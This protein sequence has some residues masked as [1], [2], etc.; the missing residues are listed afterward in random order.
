MRAFIF[1]LLLP[2]VLSACGADA[3]YA[4]DAE[5]ARA[6]YVS[7]EPP[8][9]TLVTAINNRSGE[10]GHTGLIIN[11]SQRVLW[12]PAGTWFNRA[13]P[14]RYDMFFGMNDQLV[15]IYYDYH[16]RVTYHLVI[17]TV[18]VTREVAD[19]AIRRFQAKGAAPKAF[20]SRYT[21]S[22][23]NTLPG[24]ESLPTTFFPVTTMKAFA[25]LP[26]VKTRKIYDNDSDD[27]KALLTPQT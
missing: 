3:I 18:P 6:R 17:Q 1:S 24:F 13:A 19:L 14:E 12:D 7:D 21:T 25:K 4:T 26:G 16:A 9:I 10:G 11:G 5:V 8:S 22:V 15:D 27:N 23:L 20:C 2:L